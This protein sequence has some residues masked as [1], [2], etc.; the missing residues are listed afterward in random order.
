MQIWWFLLKF[1]ASYHAD[2]PYFL[3]S[4]SKWPKWP[5]GAM[6]VTSIFYTNREYHRMHVWCK[7]GDSSPNLWQ[8]IIR[9]SQFSQ[10]SESKLPKWPWRPKSMTSTFNISREYPMMHVWCKFGDSTSDEL[11]CGQGKIYTRTD[12]WTDGQTDG[13][14]DRRRQRQYPFERPRGKNDAYATQ[15]HLMFRMISNTY[16]F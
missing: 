9:T 15:M 13:Q 16:I 10:N 1:I 3:E 2:K 4:K 5:W 12:G 11:L 7:F 14:T 6:P 8:V